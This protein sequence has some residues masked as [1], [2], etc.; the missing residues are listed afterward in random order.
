MEKTVKI[1]KKDFYGALI[2][3]V[4]GME[5]VGAYDAKDVKEF[6]EK[7]VAQ[8]DAKAIKA[9]ERAAKAKAEGDE[10]TKAVEAVIT[11][12]F[13]TADAITKQIDFEDV[14][15]SKVVARL[16]KLVAAGKVVKEQR[17]VDDHKAMCYKLAGADA[18]V[19]TEDEIEE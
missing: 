15:K 19:E 12:E 2:E 8:I 13:Q 1:T 4:E 16:T 14:T 5:T 10:L 11:A 6:L 9:K 18:D 17:K 7:Q 3:L